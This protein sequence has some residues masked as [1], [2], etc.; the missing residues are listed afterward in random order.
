MEMN[1]VCGQPSKESDF[2]GCRV[3]QMFDLIWGF[4][5]NTGEMLLSK[6]FIMD[7]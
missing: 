7:Y 2:D 6:D 3:L 1:E 5:I 4:Y